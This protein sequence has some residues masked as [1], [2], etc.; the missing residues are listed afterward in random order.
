M[1]GG[2]I[3]AGVMQAIRPAAGLL[4]LVDS[5]EFR[6][7]WELLCQTNETVRTID[8]SIKAMRPTGTTMSAALANP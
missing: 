2:A 4:A 1:M 8:E 5:S 6:D 3:P 7:H